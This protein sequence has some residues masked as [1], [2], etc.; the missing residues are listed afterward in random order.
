M[1]GII[2]VIMLVILL[3]RAGVMGLENPAFTTATYIVGLITITLTIVYGA[4]VGKWA[5]QDIVV[6]LVI[7]VFLFLLKPLIRK[8][9]DLYDLH[10][11]VKPDER[12]RIYTKYEMFGDDNDDFDNFR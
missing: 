9:L 6:A 2:F 1:L 7:L 8:L 10:N 3:Y 11:Q 4:L 12:D 5:V